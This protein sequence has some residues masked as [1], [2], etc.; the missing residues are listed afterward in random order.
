MK[1]VEYNKS[2]D[3]AVEFQDEYKAKV[4]TDYRWFQK[5]NVKNPYYPSVY[6][7]GIIGNKYSIC[8]KE[9]V[10]KEY[11][12]WNHMLERCFDEKHKKKY[13]TYE[14]VT[15]C[16]E[17]LL[18]DNFYE[19]LHSQKN[20][21]KWLNGNRWHIDKDILM[22]GNKMYSFDACCL[23]P[24]NVNVLFTKRDRCR[25]DFPIGVTENW[26]GFLARCCNP[27][28]NKRENIGTFSTPEKAFYAYKQYKENLI[29]QIANIEYNVGNITK[30]CYDA[31]MNYEVEITD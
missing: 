15:C 28:T 7:V 31:M 9:I 11:K 22:K 25:G 27:I 20:F 18:Y 17:W 4:H 6:G 8:K 3:I 2:S 13:P 1:I 14:D 21:D 29:K 16:E 12:T 10:T 26:D 5:G 24:D 23:V 19:W 30:E